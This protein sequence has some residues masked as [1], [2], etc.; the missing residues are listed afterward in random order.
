MKGGDSAVVVGPSGSGKST[1]LHIIGTLDQPD[2]GSVAINGK[3]PFELAEPELAKF[4]ND[5]TG[6][7]FQ[8]HH[9]LPQYNVLENVLI[10]ILAFH[11]DA[12]PFEQRARHL[13]ERVGLSHRLSHKPAAL[14]GGERQ[15]VAIARALINKPHL[16]LCDEPTGNL[17][18]ASAAEVAALLFEL[19]RDEQN[20]LVVV[21][22]SLELADHFAQKLTLSDG[23]FVTK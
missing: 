18:H 13:L 5:V 7:I 16:L 11:R 17:D 22:H 19:H 21:T 3:N 8:D 6:F 15:R 9:L 23:V 2:A 12:A 4:R 14:S 1:F 10:P 20:I